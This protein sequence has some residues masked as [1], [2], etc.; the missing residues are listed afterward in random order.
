MQLYVFFLQKDEYPLVLLAVF[1]EKPMPF[2]E[3]ML[4]KVAN[5]SYPKYRMD[6]LVHN[7]VV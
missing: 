7:Q 4:E 3:E 5:L 1:V 6:L 2:L